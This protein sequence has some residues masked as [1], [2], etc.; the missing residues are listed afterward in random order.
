MVGIYKITNPKGR[1]YI[2]QSSDIEKRWIQ[3]KYCDKSCVGQKLYNSIKKYGIE[4]HT[5]E[6][7]EECEVGELMS[8]EVYYKKLI[9]E[10]NK[11][12]M[13][14]VLF[15]NLYDIGS[16][17]ALSEDI[18]NK[19]RGQKRSEATKEKMRQAKLG[20]PSNSKGKKFK[21][22]TKQKMSQS[23]MGKP[24]N[25]A[26]KPFLQFDLDNN[27]IREW[28]NLADLKKNTKYSSNAV[29]LCCRNLQKS[30]YGY[31]W[32]FKE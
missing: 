22:S 15:H 25:R 17:G 8:K 3:Y 13:G 24:S 4:A 7:L 18:K 2:G 31:I 16:G 9:L 23:K 10:E 11:G 32:K 5:K 20:L 28:D 27:F 12:D 21:Q 6:I 19:L 26:S 14:K 30:A 29:N 1:V